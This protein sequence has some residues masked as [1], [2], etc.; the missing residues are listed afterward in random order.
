MCFLRVAGPV[1]LAQAEL[2]D[3]A[4]NTLQSNLLVCDIPSM[5]IS[6]SKHPSVQ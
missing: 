4:A 2:K 3:Q 6:G 5:E 1:A